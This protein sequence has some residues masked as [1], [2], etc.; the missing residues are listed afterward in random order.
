MVEGLWEQN[1]VAVIRRKNLQLLVFY[2]LPT[3]EY[4]IRGRHRHF[5]ESGLGKALPIL[6]GL[7]H[8]VIDMDTAVHSRLHLLPKHSLRATSVPAYT[9]YLFSISYFS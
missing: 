4:P 6:R 9:V 2:T 3:S 7:R 8:C 5:P 1:Q